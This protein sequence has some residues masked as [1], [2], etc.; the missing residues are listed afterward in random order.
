LGGNISLRNILFKLKESPWKKITRG[1]PKERRYAADRAPTIEEIKKIMEY[2]DRRIKAIVL[3]MSS[4]GIRLGSWDYLKWANIIPIKRGEDNKVVVVAAKIIVY[5][6]E[7][8][9]YFSFITP[10]AY[11]ALAD[12]MKYR[13]KCGEIITKDSW[14]MRDLWDVSKPYG[15]GLVTR[16]KKLA[17]LGRNESWRDE[18]NRDS[19]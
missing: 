15:K 5:A 19:R 8:D 2:P 12:W 10:E 4:S 16:P 11:Q 18:S 6:G 17:S 3:V 9:E 13:E 1:L 7:E 14:L